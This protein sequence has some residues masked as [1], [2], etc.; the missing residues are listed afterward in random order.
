MHTYIWVFVQRDMGSLFFYFFKKE[1]DRV[2][3]EAGRISRQ[4]ILY[5]WCFSLPL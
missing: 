2:T 1:I 4:T 5:I 3:T